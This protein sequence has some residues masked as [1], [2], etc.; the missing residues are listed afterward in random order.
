MPFRRQ[1]HQQLQINLL[2]PSSGPFD[3]F[4]L[5]LAVGMSGI[6]PLCAH[7]AITIIY[8]IPPPM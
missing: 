8:N 1:N 7:R 5:S 4:S 6:L 3:P 2:C